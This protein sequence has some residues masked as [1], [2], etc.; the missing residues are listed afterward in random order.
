MLK[1]RSQPFIEDKDES[2][3][4]FAPDKERTQDCFVG[5]AVM[6]SIFWREFASVF[7]V[8]RTKMLA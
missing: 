7:G 8:V 5:A 3:S 1:N 6:G 4:C 2:L